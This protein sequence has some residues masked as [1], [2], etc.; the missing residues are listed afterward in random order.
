MKI[1][2][3]LIGILTLKCSLLVSSTV[4]SLGLSGL[5]IG[6]QGGY[7]DVH[8]T[9]D[10][11]LD[12]NHYAQKITYQGFAPRVF[13]GYN[14]IPYFAPELSVIYFTKPRF[15]HIDDSDQTVEIKNNIVSVVGRFNL[16]VFKGLTIN[17][18]AGAGYIVRNGIVH[19]NIRLL[20]EG[21]FVTAI[22]GAGIN[23]AWTQR[24]SADATWMQAPSN[25]RHRLPTSNYYGV[26]IMYRFGLY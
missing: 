8:Y 9:N 26:G 13:L 22:Y 25:S 10:D 1:T 19:N 24:W 4:H 3:I 18:K 21:N 16:P 14:I 11:L 2:K 6:L 20:P 12:E 7:S 23:Y 15:Y 17:G 5:Y